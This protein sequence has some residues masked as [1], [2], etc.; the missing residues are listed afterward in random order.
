M[1]SQKAINFVEFLNFAVTIVFLQA[2][3]A[4]VDVS[5]G[6]RHTAAVTSIGHVYCWGDNTQGQCI[7]NCTQ[8]AICNET[9]DIS[10]SNTEYQ[11]NLTKEET[12]ITQND[13]ESNLSTA[14]ETNRNQIS[15]QASSENRNQ[16]DSDENKSEFSDSQT[17]KHSKDKILVPLKITVTHNS[18]SCVNRSSGE[19]S[20]LVRNGGKSSKVSEWKDSGGRSLSL[21][22]G[23][24]EDRKS[25]RRLTGGSSRQL[26]NTQSVLE[27]GCDENEQEKSGQNQV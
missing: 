6:A 13:F 4:V 12:E 3:A 17:E 26:L 23:L 21:G 22:S 11:R 1:L 5:C 19:K 15:S 16:S 2:D 10:A 7:G 18:A 25:G 20:S 27:E 24:N 14:G 8:K 9:N